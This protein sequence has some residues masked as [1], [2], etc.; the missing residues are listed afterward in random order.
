MVVVAEQAMESN[1]RLSDAHVKDDPSEGD[2]SGS[3]EDDIKATDKAR[4]RKK[5]SPTKR[6]KIDHEPSLLFEVL[7]RRPS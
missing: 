7:L 5:Q 4:R 6:R 1:H 3:V 2:L